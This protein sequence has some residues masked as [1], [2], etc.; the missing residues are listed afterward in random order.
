MVHVLCLHLL[1]YCIA[2]NMNTL[3]D[4]T[5]LTPTTKDG[6]ALVLALITFLQGFEQRMTTMFTSAIT[7]RDEKIDVLT[8]QLK[9]AKDR[10][11]KLEE[12]IE[13]NDSYERRDTLVL[14]GSKILAPPTPAK[15]ENIVQLSRNL[16][17]ENLG[18]SVPE[19]EISVTHR[20]SS[21]DGRS[22]QRSVIIKFCR[23]NMK[24]DILNAA[25]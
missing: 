18:V 23:R 10:L 22:D 4:L 8:E 24:V 17:R 25:R 19:N 11:N 13:N 9:N 21:R 16:I 14:S 12:R 1:R 5:K 7:E 20:L 3:S 6:K 2:R 15:D